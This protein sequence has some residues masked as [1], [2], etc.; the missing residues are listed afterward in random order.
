M[1]RRERFKESGYSYF[2]VKSQQTHERKEQNHE[3]LSELSHQ[4]K[5]EGGDART[6]G[7]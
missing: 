4:S 3:N 2:K 7:R 1:V 5:F 6:K